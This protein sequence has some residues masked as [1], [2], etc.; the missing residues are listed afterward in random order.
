MKSSRMPQWKR[1]AVGRKMR[2]WRRARRVLRQPVQ[3]FKRSTYTQTFQ[4]TSTAGF[5]SN[6][7]V[8]RLS[9]IPNSS[10]FIGLY[11]QYKIN[12]V[13]VQVIPRINSAEIAQAVSQVASVIDYDDSVVPANMNTL[14]QYQNFKL[15][16]GTKIHSR[17]LKPKISIPTTGAGTMVAKSQWL[18]VATPD[19]P[20]YGIKYGFPQTPNAQTF[21]IKIDFYL[22]FKNVR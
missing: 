22:A 19:V 14:V 18:D 21:D 4:V 15:T 9:D 8:F 5:T 16:Q 6:A 7:V 13:K 17:Y 20:H 10:E 12:A 3:Y 11:D 2:P 1:K